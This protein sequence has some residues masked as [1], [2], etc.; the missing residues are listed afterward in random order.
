MASGWAKD[1]DIQQQI[2]NNIEDAVSQVRRH[3]STGLSLHFCEEC[4]DIIPERRRLAILGVRLCVN[5]QSH[6]E[7]R[8]SSDSLINRRASKAS[9]LR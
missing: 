7:N 2:D 6:I 1:G 4:G 9:Q 8:T 5:C 3:I